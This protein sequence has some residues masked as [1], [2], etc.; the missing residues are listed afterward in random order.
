LPGAVVFDV[1]HV[2]Y[3]WDPRYLYEKIIADPAELDWFLGHVVTRAWHFQHDAGRRF[4][5]T[6]AE[7]IA[8]YPDQADRIRAF[9]DR[10]NET[11]PGPVPGMPGLVADLDAA[12]VPLFAITN[13]GAEFWAKWRPTIPL[14]DRFAGIVVSGEEGIM[15][16]APEIYA[17]ALARFGLAPGDGA[18]IDDRAD[19]VAAADAAG[20]IGHVFV[21]AAD[22]RAWLTGLHLL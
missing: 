4:A 17:L 15:K 1:G 22:T 20:L 14:F 9:A 19:N 13:Y 16:P 6:S 18:F 3:D 8:Q 2:L 11:L 21:D 12:G 5:D 7:L 10:W